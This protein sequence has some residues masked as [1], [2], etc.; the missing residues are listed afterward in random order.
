MTLDNYLASI[1]FADS[2]WDPREPSQLMMKE[3]WRQTAYNPE[4]RAASLVLHAIRNAAQLVSVAPD[5]ALAYVLSPE[6]KLK[7]WRDF[8]Q[9]WN[10]YLQSGAVD[11]ELNAINRI[12]GMACGRD[13]YVGTMHN[14]QTYVLEIVEQLK[15]PTFRKRAGEVYNAVW[16]VQVYETA[17]ATSP[18]VTPSSSREL[19]SA[20]S[21]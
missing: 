11:Q 16:G 12:S 4:L 10:A 1:N 3:L 9:N 13:A 15:Q 5:E 7:V 8:A 21:S 2:Y 19:S 17:R 18:T 20:H 14:A 6:G